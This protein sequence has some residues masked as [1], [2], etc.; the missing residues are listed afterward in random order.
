M[1]ALILSS[2]LLLCAGATAA[3]FQQRAYQRETITRAKDL[4]GGDPERGRHAAHALGCVA[5]HEIPRVPGSRAAV[6]PSLAKFG[7]R[8][9]LAGAA[10]NTPEQLTQFLRDPRS[11]APKSAMPNLR[12]SERDI[13]DLSAFLYTLR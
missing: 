6:G 3:V 12:L 4:T 13:R 9:Y 2:I 1:R 7:R 10:D 11:V 5:C 8:P